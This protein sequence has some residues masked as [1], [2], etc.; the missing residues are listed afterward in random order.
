MPDGSWS[1]PTQKDVEAK[2][3][4][5]ARHAPI[6][7]WLLAT[8]DCQ[9]CVDPQMPDAINAFVILGEPNVIHTMFVK[10][11]LQKL[12]LARPMVEDLLGDRLRSQQVVTMDLP[13]VSAILGHSWPPNWQLDPTWI[14]TRMIE[15]TS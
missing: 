10:R 12:G 11:D 8:Q 3:S 1:L 6:L 2:R 5:K 13:Q 9:L 7:N 14:V 4:F 15:E